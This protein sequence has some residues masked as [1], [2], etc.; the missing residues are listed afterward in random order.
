MRHASIYFIRSRGPPSYLYPKSALGEG[1]ALPSPFALPPQI[2]ADSNN[3][4]KGPNSWCD[5]TV[6]ALKKPDAIARIRSLQK[7]L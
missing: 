2:R 7:S 5:P 3:K 1:P 6:R 4:R